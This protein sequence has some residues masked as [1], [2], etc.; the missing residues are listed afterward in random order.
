MTKLSKAVNDY[1]AL[2]RALGFKMIEVSRSL[3]DFVKFA[4]RERASRIT[5]DLAVRWAKQSPSVQPS[6]WAT[7]LRIVRQLAEY[8]STIDSRTEVP[9]RDL[10]PFG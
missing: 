8:L 6:R 1:V 2:R 5:V 3:A 7:R 10:L 9:P 4:G